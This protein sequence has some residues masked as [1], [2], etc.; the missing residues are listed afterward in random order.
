MRILRISC[1]VSLVYLHIIYILRIVCTMQYV[2][3][4]K[5]EGIFFAGKLA[6]LNRSLQSNKGTFHASGMA[7]IKPI[8]SE[9]ND[10]TPSSS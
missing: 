6:S 8:P 7:G 10:W 2:T 4:I 1:I 9:S 3:R 5:S